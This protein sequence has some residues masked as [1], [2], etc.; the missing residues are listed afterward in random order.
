MV[1]GAERSLCANLAAACKY[2][3]DHLQSH[4][5][6]LDKA[7]LIYTTGFFITSSVESLLKVASYA[8]EKDIPMGFNLSAP[9][10]IQF[11]LDNVKAALKHADFVFCNEDES[12]AWGKSQGMPDE[13]T[14]QEIGKNL[15]S[16]EKVG[17]RPRVAILTNGPEPVVVATGSTT[18]GEPTVETFDV[19][20][21]KS[22]LV[23][24][25]GAGDAF[26]GAFLAE[27]ALDKPLSDCIKAGIYLSTEVV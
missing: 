13:A 20:A 19:P 7:K 9:F 16:F 25:N 1:N 6:E 21:L 26:V 10:L 14:K 5:G 17:K 22:A 12:A 8:T 23:D 2:S 15:A 3:P 18:G 11:E 24:T 4:M 27:M